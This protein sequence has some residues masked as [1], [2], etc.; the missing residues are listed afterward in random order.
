[1][2]LQKLTLDM[3]KAKYDLLARCVAWDSSMWSNNVQLP[4]QLTAISVWLHNL[5]PHRDCSNVGQDVRLMK[6]HSKEP[7]ILSL[8]QRGWSCPL[9]LLCCPL[10]FLRHLH[11]FCFLGTAAVLGYCAG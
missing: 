2:G 1:V 11:S 8:W 9:H 4:D 5:L 10:G 7:N 3:L 6:C